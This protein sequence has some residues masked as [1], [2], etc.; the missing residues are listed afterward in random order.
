MKKETTEQSAK[1]GYQNFRLFLQAELT[2]RCGKNPN[3]S[4]RSF[5]RG[6]HIHHGT[7]S[8]ILRG[9]RP[10]SEKM[11]MDLAQSLSLAP[12]EVQAFKKNGA[13]TKT[14]IAY[15]DLTLDAFTVISE[16]YHDAILELMGLKTFKNDPKWISKMLGIT[17]SEVNIAIERLL[18]LELIEIAPSG[19]WINHG[20]HTQIGI[21]SPYTTTALKK[22]QKQVLKMAAEAV[23]EIP[24]NRRHN[25]SSTVAINV[26]DLDEIKRRLN[27]FR[28]SLT[29]FIQRKEVRADQVYQLG[30]CFYP[31]TGR[32]GNEL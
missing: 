14:D 22:Y 18:R 20:T 2:R 25:I 24:K 10:L 31:L 32:K 4:L 28:R 17:V 27:E 3:Y 15:R 12:K 16:W 21:D 5:A 8:Q 9:K 29:K 6:L 26:G 13:S 19:K 1:T 7:L 23:D 30:L 11:F